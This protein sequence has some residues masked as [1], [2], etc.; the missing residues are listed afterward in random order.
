MDPSQMCGGV[1]FLEKKRYEGERFNVI[2][3]TT[4]GWMGVKFRG[5]KH[6]VTLLRMAP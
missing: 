4:R 3:F 1:S 2:S 5:K 6:Y